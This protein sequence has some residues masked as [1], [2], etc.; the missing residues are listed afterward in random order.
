MNAKSIES[1]NLYAVRV[2]RMI[3]MGIANGKN[4][5]I[6]RFAYS[7]YNTTVWD[8]NDVSWTE[9]L[10]AQLNEVADSIKNGCYWKTGVFFSIIAAEDRFFWECIGVNM[11]TWKD[12]ELI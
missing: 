10:C 6:D 11:K 2:I 4:S 9:H 12:I 8:E 1:Q 7:L 5:Y 3:L